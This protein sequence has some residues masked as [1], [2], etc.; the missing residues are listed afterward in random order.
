MDTDTQDVNTEVDSS[1]TSK[2]VMADSSSDKG[3]GSEAKVDVKPLA[4]IGDVAKAA[5]D[6]AVQ[7]EPGESPETEDEGD[8]R[9]LSSN[10]TEGKKDKEKSETEEETSDADGD[11]KTEGDEEKTE[12]EDKPG[13]TPEHI[14]YARFQETIKEK[15]TLESTLKEVQPLADAHKSV[16]EFCQSNRI[17]QE[18]FQEGMEMLRLINS[19]PEGARAA[20]EPIWNQLNG[21]TG[22]TLPEDLAKEVEEGVLSESR[23]KEIAKLRGKESIANSRKQLSQAELGQQQVKQFATQLD[24]SIGAW[25]NGK[26]GMD[27]GYKPKASADAPDGKYEYVSDRFFKL[28]SANPPKTVA[29]A[30]RFA[31]QAYA[32]V[33]KSF[34]SFAPKPQGTNKSISST[35]SSTNSTKAPGSVKEAVAAALAK[36]GA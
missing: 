28:M 2:D 24:Q 1:D 3:T 5:F 27:T 19:D 36:H 15:Q 20:L 7:A 4:T 9:I 8:G 6:K 16:V 31:E 17:T 33:S 11:K 22:N 32:E 10:S 29:E 25:A 18:Q 34:A 13:K 14:P 26:M 21:V 23:A 35:K 30:V 12:G